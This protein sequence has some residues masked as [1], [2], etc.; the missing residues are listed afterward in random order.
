MLFRFMELNTSKFVW[1]QWKHENRDGEKE[2][3][4]EENHKPTQVLEDMV[5]ALLFLVESLS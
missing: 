5:T 1:P 4:F 3:I 2:G